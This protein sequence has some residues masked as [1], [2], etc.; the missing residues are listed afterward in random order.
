MR[1]IHTADWHLGHSLNGW[2]R[3]DEHSLYFRRLADVIEQEEADVLLVAGDIF[4]SS[5][6]SGEVQRL[7]YDALAS[8]KRRRP[9]LITVISGGNHDPAQRLEAPMPVLRA[10]DVHVVATVQRRGGRIDIDR[11][12][13]PIP[14]PDGTP[15]LYVLAIPFLR[16]SDLTGLNDEGTDPVVDAARRFYAEITAQAA[17]IAG[18]VPIIATSHLHCAGGLESEGAERRIL[19]GGA[20][21]VPPS[22]F[23]DR[24]AYVALGH[25]HG[26]QTLKGGRV[27][28]SGACFPLSSSEI[29]HDHGVTLIELL[30]GALTHRHISIERPAQML[31]LPAS[32]TIALDDLPAALGQIAF[33]D[34]LPMGLRPLVYLELAPTDAASVLMAD[35]A[36]CVAE[37]GLRLG[38]ARVQRQERHEGEEIPPPPASLRETDPETLFVEAFRASAGIEPEARH[39]DAFRDIIAG[40]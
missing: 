33:D 36:R 27:R 8:F 17:E 2:A 37:R 16:A 15:A 38:G 31:R 10:L 21:A 6:P 28:Y 34:T 23:P 14:G 30:N 11:H 24:L 9:N 18:D 13:V 4:D 32:G 25:L 39:L 22:I 26:Q 20:H 5:N 35:A 1:I 29:R 40:E 7:L 19:I 3:E 12:L